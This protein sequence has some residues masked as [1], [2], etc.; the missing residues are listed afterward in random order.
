[1]TTFTVRAYWL[2]LALVPILG[3]GT[4]ASSNGTDAAPQSSAN[5]NLIFVVS[6]DR[7]F[8]ASDD[9]NP[10]TANLTSKGLQRALLL[11]PYLQE[12]ILGNNNANGIYAL[13][14][15]T[16]LQTA[17]QY[18]DMVAIE[19]IQQFAL[20]NQ[21]SLPQSPLG[22]TLYKAN[23]FP[24]NVSYANGQTIPGVAPPLIVS[25][26]CQGLDFTD[27]NGDNEMLIASILSYG[28]P[29]YFVFSAPW[30]TVQDVLNKV[31]ASRKFNLSLP[32]IYQG[33]N[34]IYALSVSTSGTASLT[35][36]DSNL[37]PPSSD[38]VLPAHG[39]SSAACSKSQFHIVVNTPTPP[40][41]NTN[42]TMYLIRHAEAHPTPGWDDGNYVA[43]GQW[44]AL[45]LPIA[46]K[47]KI[48]PDEVYSIDPA[49]AGP[50][51]NLDFSYV[52]PA[53]TVAP[54]AIVNNLP[55]HLAAGFALNDISDVTQNTIDFFFS[56]TQFSNR[57]I[58]LAWEHEH[59][60]PLVNAL[61][62]SYGS[63]QTVPS[64]PQDDYDSVWKVSLDNSGNLSVDNSICEGIDSSTLPKTAPMF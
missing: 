13:E 4:P 63:N 5:I 9:F 37:T 57:K 11:A 41:S 56:S 51:G 64:W 35:T 54:Y 53:L 20:L 30:E 40:V 21:I 31:N 23:S 58:L 38:P 15:M 18:P 22:S 49:Q 24:I 39:I 6:E 44:R 62:K 25:P 45:D 47:G 27:Q 42:E 16:H 2:A 60:P 29:G 48:S 3:C 46:L 12:T 7:N 10:V 50:S 26:G 52:R 61:L 19:T 55:Y 43:A 1:M 33:P 14:P 8:N 28:T 34:T 17:N 36:Y 59:L 32:S